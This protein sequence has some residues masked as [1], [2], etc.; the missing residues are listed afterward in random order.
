MPFNEYTIDRRE[1]IDVVAGLNRLSI[2][3]GRYCTKDPWEISVL[4]NYPGV[5]LTSSTPDPT[6]PTEQETIATELAGV[7][8]GLSSTK[9]AEAVLE[10]AITK[11][12]EGK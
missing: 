9:Q 4:S 11:F 10:S 2:E 1:G 6:P 5:V 8:A 7:E 3:R 12:Q